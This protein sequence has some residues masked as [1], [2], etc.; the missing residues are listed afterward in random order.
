MK[1]E[2]LIADVMAAGSPDTAEHVILEVI[3]AGLFLVNPGGFCGGGYTLW[4]RNR[5]L[6]V[7]TLLRDI[8]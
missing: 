2:W 4:C 3:V 1:M 6:A 7:I 5:I 8:Y